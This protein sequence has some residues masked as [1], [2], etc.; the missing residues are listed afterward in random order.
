M[1][2]KIV[3]RTITT[4]IIAA[5]CYLAYCIGP[6]WSAI[7]FAVGLISAAL[8]RIQKLER[9]VDAIL[10]GVTVETKKDVH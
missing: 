2:E 3:A 5:I 4:L 10:E 1:L 8:N 9:K 6:V 7:L